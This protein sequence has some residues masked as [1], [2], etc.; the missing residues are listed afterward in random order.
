MYIINRLD[1]NFG[2]GFEVCKPLWANEEQIEYIIGLCAYF[3][4]KNQGDLPLPFET[5]MALKCPHAITVLQV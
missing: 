1:F 4:P 3:Q 5:A 2:Q